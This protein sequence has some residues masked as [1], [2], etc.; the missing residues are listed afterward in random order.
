MLE[1]KSDERKKNKV[2]SKKTRVKSEDIK[3]SLRE[4]IKNNRFFTK[5]KIIYFLILLCNVVMV[6]YCASKNKVHYVKV[7]DTRRFMI[8]LLF[9]YVVLDFILFYIF[10][11][12]IY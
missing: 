3:L 2:S 12:K 5:E 7:L 6:I 1:K 9:L 11:I 10:T 4:R 8:A